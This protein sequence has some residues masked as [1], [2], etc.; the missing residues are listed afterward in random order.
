MLPWIRRTTHAYQKTVII[1]AVCLVTVFLYGLVASPVS[2]QSAA[3]S[4]TDT[5]G[6]TPV[7]QGTVLAQAV[8][9]RVI[10]A[11][12]I[13]A[14]FALLG[15]IVILIIIYA[16]YLIMTSGGNEEQV[17]TGKRMLVNA[18]IG[19]IIIFTALA[20]V[21]FVLNALT[22]ANGGQN[23]GSGGRPSGLQSFTGSGA[24]GPIIR[25]HYPERDQV[26]VY[27][28][29]KIVVTF[30]EPID[31]A[32][33]IVDSNH[34]NIL[35][36]C[37]QPINTPRIEW[38]RDCDRLVTSSVRIYPTEEPS[39]IIEA[40]AMTSRSGTDNQTYSFVFQPLIPPDDL[41]GSPTT[42]V[43]YTVTLLDAIHKVNGRSAFE[44]TR[45]GRYEWQ[46]ITATR[47]D[48]TAP[49]I[50]SIYPSHL[51]RISRN[52]IVQIVFNEPMDPTSVQGQS[53][54]FTNILFGT[55]TVSNSTVLPAGDW[56]LSNGYRTVE[57]VPN[58]Q[59]GR[60]SCGDV[61]YCLQLPC[62]NPNDA[63]CSA[64]YTVLVRSARTLPNVA[65]SDF[66]SIPFSGVSDI[67]GN[68][69][70][71]GPESSRDRSTGVIPGN[72]R[73]ADL[74]RP[75]IPNVQRVSEVEKADDNFWWNFTVDNSVD[76]VA[77]FIASVTPGIDE[78]AV[79]ETA[80]LSIRFSRRMWSDTLATI[81]VEEYPASTT[82]DPLWYV[83]RS[84]QVADTTNALVTVANIQHRIFGPNDSDT[85]Y[86]P[87]VPSSVRSLQQNCLYPG[88]GPAAAGN[89][90]TV[91]RTA[92]GQQ[93]VTNCLPSTDVI[94]E[95]T[96]TACVQTTLLTDQGQNLQL[97]PS[98]TQC[99]STLRRQDV[100]P[101]SGS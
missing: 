61:M 59:C 96:D 82:T 66:T 16:G 65:N 38:A 33:M 12:I 77:P 69:L 76:R 87:S 15:I 52:T 30:R 98:I 46:F 44:Q 14:A 31:A 8:D 99:L 40:A 73:H 48:T 10:V 60:N 72:G 6:L 7:A 18:V 36:D 90:C 4:T 34:S 53:A 88:R 41:L 3:S 51:D 95:D 26:D 74:N 56:R 9:I 93:T 28:N 43:S 13:R 24:L 83:A 42:T 67:A 1:L 85:Y 21:Q 47:S 62:T 39:H 23:L 97:Q 75:N 27:R 94:D 100:S 29:S 45:S 101:P 70:D 86:F 55:S 25:D 81:A 32:S 20:I 22:G 92:N 89:T 79:A 63:T 80:P 49:T 50:E 84:S 68:A 5:F 71:T 78:Q 91:T 35:G 37:V 58:E 57:F 54:A 64:E 17:S 11:R 19:L 2:A